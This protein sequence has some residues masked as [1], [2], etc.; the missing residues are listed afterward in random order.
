MEHVNENASTSMGHFPNLRTCCGI[1]AY[2][3]RAKTALTHV[4]ETS[5]V[6]HSSGSRA[7]IIVGCNWAPKGGKNNESF[8]TTIMKIL[9]V[10]ESYWLAKYLSGAP[11][12]TYE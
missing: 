9:D 6:C 4:K 5:G 7:S 3:Y 11:S 10:L 12:V 8:E 1:K 2:F